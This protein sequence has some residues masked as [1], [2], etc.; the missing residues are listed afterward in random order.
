MKAAY[1]YQ[2]CRLC[3]VHFEDTQ[4]MNAASKNKLVWTAVP[5]IFPA[6]PNPPKPIRLKRPCRRE[7]LPLACTK[8]TKVEPDCEHGEDDKSE[9]GN[10]VDFEIKEEDIEMKEVVE[11]N[12]E[13]PE[14]EESGSTARRGEKRV[15]SPFHSPETEK[16][17]PEVEQVW[18][19][20]E[21]DKSEAGNM[22]DFE[23]KEE[24]IEM[25]EVVEVNQENPENEE[26]GSTARRGEK[27]VLS[28]FHSP[29][30]EKQRPEVEQVWIK[31]E[32]K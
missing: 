5:T 10:M 4:F 8:K 24:D 28:P 12:Q 15:L 27:R 7:R 23:I 29:E 18:I 16:Q 32:R 30:T 11:V 31:E 2:N 21:H 14:N 1:L 20:E 25:K 6:V 3:S 26:S 17:R 22:V 9:A 19:K 13:N